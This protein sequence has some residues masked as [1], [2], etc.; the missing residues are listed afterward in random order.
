MGGAALQDKRS[1]QSSAGCRGRALKG[2]QGSDSAPAP[3][4]QRALCQVCLAPRTGA[5]PGQGSSSLQPSVER[6]KPES[7]NSSRHVEVVADTRN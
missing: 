4:Q 2:H 7:R 1:P 5:Q 6:A 3:Q